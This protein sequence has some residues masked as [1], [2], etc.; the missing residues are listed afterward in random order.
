M[1]ITKYKNGNVQVELLKDGTKTREFSG[2]EKVNFPESVDVKITDY[3]NVGCRF[4][5]ENSTI[6]G[7]HGDLSFAIKVLDKIKIPCE[8]AIG[9]GNPLSHPRLKWFI[10][11]LKKQGKI[12]N[13]TV[14]AL[15][16]DNDV[17]KYNCYG[18]GVSYKK[19]EHKKILKYW[20]DNCV[21][22]LIAGYH[23]IE[24]LRTCLKDFKKVLVLGYKN[25]GRAKKY[26]LRNNLSQKIKE[27]NF[28]IGDYLGEG[29]LCF[30]NLA[31]SQLDVKRFY[32][33]KSWD[34]IY[35]GEDGVRSF[36]YDFVKKEKA[37]SS[38]NIERRKIAKP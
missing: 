1:I 16:F 6:Q 2:K 18:V 33:K 8:V 29:I 9:G 32:L 17:F 35:L 15:H 34:K 5:H 38:A 4:C 14:N 23:T 12:P 26:N 24:E 11:E 10:G 28:R 3:C 36:Y 31:I 22:H 21:I 7:K 30:D 37:I 13:I 20:K 25:I 27:W 19:E